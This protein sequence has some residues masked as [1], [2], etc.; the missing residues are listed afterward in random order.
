MSTA[1]IINLTPQDITIIADG[2]STTFK[3]SGDVC[4]ITTTTEERE[5]INGLPTISIKY[6]EIE[7]LPF[8]RKDTFFIVSILVG[9]NHGTDRSDLIGP[10]TNRAIR[11]TNGNI[12][13]C[14]CFV[15]Y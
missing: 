1:E 13:G 4:R 2:K 3:R 8:P 15:R 6:G 12:L 10:D 11:D 9:Q 14:P 5:P 7:N